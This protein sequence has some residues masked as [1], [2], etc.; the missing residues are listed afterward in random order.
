MAPRYC[1]CPHLLEL[2]V[3]NGRGQGGLWQAAVSPYQGIRGE[4]IPLRHPFSD[5]SVVCVVA[6]ILV[7]VVLRCYGVV[8]GGVLW[9]V[10]VTCIR[11]RSRFFTFAR[12]KK[13]IPTRNSTPLPR[14][15]ME[16]YTV[17]L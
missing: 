14:I 17:P 1:C 3:E 12:S 6:V 10:A 7:V 4:V 15:Q 13:F 16:D 5:V 2:G 8:V 9:F 11:K